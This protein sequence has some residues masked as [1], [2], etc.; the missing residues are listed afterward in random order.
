MIVPLILLQACERQPES[1]RK[2]KL[3]EQGSTGE[4]GKRFTSTI[5]LAPGARRAIAVMFFENNT[6][7]QRL[8][9]L[10]KGLTEMFIRSLSQ[11]SSLSVL[12]TDRI[13]EIMQ[14]AG[15]TASTQPLDFQ[16]AAIVSREANVEAILTGAIS[17]R[18]DSL[19]I[20]VRV[21][22]PNQGKILREESVE[23][24][25]LDALF[26]MVDQLTQRVKNTL[27]LSLEQQERA[28]GIADLSTSS[29][30]AWRFYT[31]GLDLE[32]KAMVNEAV[33]QYAEA[34]KADPAF[35]AAYYKLSLYLYSQGERQKGLQYFQKL[36]ALRARAT[37]KEQYQI[38]RLESGIRGDVRQ[39]IEISKRW[40][41]Q[42]PDDIDAN[43]NLGDLYFSL[44]NYDEALR[45]Y[46]AILA[47]DPKYKMAYN[48]IGYCYARRGDLTNAAAIMRQYQELVPTE[49]NP[50]DS[51][52]E[53]YFN[54][55]EYKLAE[56]NLLRSLKND[57]N[58]APSWLSLSE[59]YLEQD[60]PEKALEVIN[61]FLAKV[62]AP[63]SRADGYAQR[64]FIQWRLG[65]MEQAIGDFQN[66]VESRFSSYRAT[67][68]VYELYL[69]KGDT[70]GAKQ[71][72]LKNYT[73]IRDSLVNN[74]PIYLVYLA[75]LGL[76]YDVNAVETI[77]IIERLLARETTPNVRM[78]GN[79]YLPL[80]YLK[81][82][83][84]ADFDRVGS[85]FAAD[86][87]SHL[88]D[89]REGLSAREIWKSFLVFNQHA[90]DS[91]QDGIALYQQL[92]RYCQDQ[93]LTS[94]E[95]IL[96]LFL[97]DLYTHRGNKAKA[98]EELG[99]V[100][101]PS[102]DRWLTIAPYDNSNGFQR[103]YPPER[104]LKVSN[105]ASRQRA[106]PFWQHLQDG[107]NDGYIDLKQVYAKYNW[108]VGYGLIY[109][110]S[111]DKRKVQI[112][113]GTNDSAK[114]WLN[115]REVWRMNMGRDA[116]F[117]N[118]IVTVDLQQGLNKVVLKVC[119][120]INEWGFY[121]RVTDA[122]GRGM[123]DIEFIAGDDIK[124]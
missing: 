37:V 84:V 14:Q 105:S 29:L 65:H 79:L 11:S 52:G 104:G 94:P 72:L 48:Q 1:R 98:E 90:G 70:L 117:D 18:G 92:I 16:L 12:S 80:L 59:V 115:D 108:S 107:A 23:G 56:K 19:K 15:Q 66:F 30:E 24:K 100:G 17:R 73:F 106:Q 55:G 110:K 111:P 9:W 62:K 122:E 36:K 54:Y 60:K 91:P 93:N 21:H 78:W 114:L 50:F 40:L 4:S 3:A 35:I 96:R 120:R 102:E 116:V 33:A 124:S 97:A 99:K 81:A 43:F 10:Q 61:Q 74:E 64:G 39:V 47:I 123:T 46:Q 82:G 20:D 5:H 101:A 22:E 109:I 77:G 7:D 2:I 112:R 68:W 32:Q 76:W 8:E 71:S 95:M 13:F 87:T 103:K 51:M 53:I 28:R 75:N 119:N 113:L 83:R 118:D 45:Y 34:V 31:A 121:F 41:E 67:T 69:E 49:P 27:T 44:Q 88:K 6:G 86:F 85:Q 42:N 58:F 63:R 57:E 26:T 25:D 89:V 38:D